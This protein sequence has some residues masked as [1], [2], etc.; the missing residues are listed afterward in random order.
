MYSTASETVRYLRESRG[1]VSGEE[2]AG[3]LG[4]T[5]A[6][7]WK[8]ISSLRERGFGIT[9]VTNRGYRLDSVPDLPSEE[10]LH[11]LLGTTLIGS[12]IEYHPV[13]PSTNTRAMSLGHQGYPEGTVVTADSQTAGKARDGGIWASPPG[14]NLYLSVLLKPGVAADMLYRLHGIALGALRESV[15]AYCPDLPLEILDTGLYCRGNKIGGVLCE[16]CGEIGRIHHAVAGIGLNVTHHP[17]SAPAS[18]ITELSGTTPSRAELTV[19][20]LEALERH[21]LKWMRSVENG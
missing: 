19:T 7:V 14:K 11:S 12:V 13:I 16:A 10:V 21:Y 15:G 2:I 9:S 1:F 3:K 18:S 17:E 4:I 6:A 5:R 20:L 8:H